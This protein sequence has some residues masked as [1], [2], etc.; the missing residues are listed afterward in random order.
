MT[1]R[2][3]R[4]VQ[5]QT[6]APWRQRASTPRC[7]RGAWRYACRG[8]GAGASAVAIALG[9]GASPVLAGTSTSSVPPALRAQARE[10]YA[11]V[12]RYERSTTLAE[13]AR[14]RSAARRVGK[15]IDACQ[16]PYLKRLLSKR[17]IKLDMLWNDA[18]LLQTYQ[19]D[20]GPVAKQLATLAASWAALA[21]R[22]RT[23]NEFVHAVATEFR[24]TL[25]AA[26]FD[27]CAFVKAIGAH[28]LSY[29]WAKQSPYG[30]QAARWWR[31]MLQA[32]ERT[33]SFWR[34]VLP[35]P[36]GPGEAPPSTTGARL[37]TTKQLE[38]LAN[39][40]GELS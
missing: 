35:T 8:V 30:V 3:V 2:G 11:A 40:P 17:A 37:F 12:G 32:G 27:S 34:Y 19:A 26:P 9:L 38:V 21:L 22:N 15:V 20:V 29:V 33:N 31:R 28:N 18:T 1:R 7:R 5:V 16:A 23:M 4:T 10:L 14:A 13:R 25:D 36:A 6:V 24:A 39:L